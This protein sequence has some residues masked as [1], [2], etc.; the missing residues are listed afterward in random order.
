M[1]IFSPDMRS[2]LASD[3]HYTNRQIFR[4]VFETDDH[5]IR[6]F[7]LSDVNSSSSTMFNVVNLSR[8]DNHRFEAYVVRKWCSNISFNSTHTRIHR[9]TIRTL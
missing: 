4:V 8:V 3:P 6:D 9:Y 1:T 2:D 7:N 5:T